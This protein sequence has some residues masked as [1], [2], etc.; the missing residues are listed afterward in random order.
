LAHHDVN[1]STLLKILPIPQNE[2]PFMNTSEATEKVKW[3][4]RERQRGKEYP[5]FMVALN[6][7]RVRVA[8]DIPSASVFKTTR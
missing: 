4:D 5:F 6:V 8:S 2:V 3:P 7:S 1:G